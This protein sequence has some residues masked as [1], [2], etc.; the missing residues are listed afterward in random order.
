MSYGI[1]GHIGIGKE[2]TWGTAVAASAYLEAFSEG[3][4]PTIDRFPTKNIIGRLYEPDDAAGLTRVAGDIVLAANPEIMGYLLNGALGVQSGAE[5]LSGFLY[6]SEFTFNTSD[7][8]TT[9]PVP[10]YTYE[11]FR[12][13]TSAQQIAGGAITALQISGQ[14]NQDLR[15]AASIIGKSSTH[16]APTSPSYV[17]SPVEPFMFN[18][19]SISIG[20][21]ANA[22]LES[23]T[24]NIDNRMS[25]KGTLNNTALIAKIR[26]D[27]GQGVRFSGTLEFENITE[28][29][30]FEAQT[31]QAMSVSFT[32]AGSFQ[33]VMDMPRVVYETY[34]IGMAGRERI[35][36]AFDSIVRHHTGSDQALA[37]TLTT[38]TSGF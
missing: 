27:D 5:V 28:Y 36:A 1:A 7:D 32:K 26:R 17:G 16:I 34:Q 21:A 13:V 6:T 12:D 25:G 37:I 23:F 30:K 29:Q 20:G 38:I 3:L 24:L 8:S 11:V 4:I 15:I 9:C 10:A 33:V 35:V 18:T 31:E 2:T 22:N 19:C 14:V